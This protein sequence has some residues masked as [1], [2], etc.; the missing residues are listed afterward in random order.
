MGMISTISARAYMLVRD[1]RSAGVHGGGSISGT[2]VRTLNTVLKN[3]IPNASLAANQLTLPPGTYLLQALA[4]CYGGESHKAHIYSVT[5]AAVLM[6]GSSERVWSASDVSSC[7]VVRVELVL[8]AQKVIELRHYIATPQAIVGLG[9]A[10][11]SGI[12]VYAQIV[13]EKV[14]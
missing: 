12:E 4:P 5:D 2:Q 8:T 10:V 3:T 11:A 9:Y 13:L 7:S 14:R 6:Y 1:E